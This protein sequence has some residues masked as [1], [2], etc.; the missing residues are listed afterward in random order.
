MKTN[1][2]PSKY[3]IKNWVE[4]YV[5]E[6]D[7]FFIQKENL[8]VFEEEIGKVLL[9]PKDEFFNHASYK[10]IQLANSYEYWNL[11]KEVDFV[12]VANANWITELPP[13][14]KERLLQI[15]LKMN[16]GLIFP[17]S[18][19]SEI[20]LLLEENIVKGNENES[21]VLYSNLWEKLSFSI[22]EQL[23]KKYS[24]QWDEWVSEDIPE[25]LPMIMKKYTNTFP[26]EG[27]SN[28][29]AA[30]L[31]AITQ[32]EWMIHEW[33]HP[34]TFKETLD[35]TH[36]QVKTEELIEGDVAVW[37]TA[38]GQ[39]Q[40]ASY[41]V[42]NLFFFNKNGQTFFNPWR[43]INFRELQAE[44]KRYSLTIYRMK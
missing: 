16:R 44:W 20:P 32:Q 8:P 6:K 11:S 3:Q 41:H 36:R 19:F 38:E 7:F 4:K 29:L 2:Q 18:Y 43:I 37:G 5:P 26:T 1:I 30:T 9:I 23:V 34:Q 35:R 39:I 42:G 31:F 25:R 13:S 24:Q 14:K 15:Q 17:L 28:C 27:G 10:Q 40:H 12:M 33:V 21:V 22:K